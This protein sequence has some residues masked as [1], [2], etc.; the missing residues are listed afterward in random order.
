MK[1]L[2]AL[3]FSLIFIFSSFADKRE[4][5]R[6]SMG[7]LTGTA[8]T[9]SYGRTTYRDAL[10]RTQGTATTSRGTTT[11]RDAQGRTQGTRR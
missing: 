4:E 10:G 2:I 7:R 8:T 11:Y 1:I 9:D 3:L 5:F 6:D